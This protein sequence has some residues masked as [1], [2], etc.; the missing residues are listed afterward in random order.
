MLIAF[1]DE[2]YVFWLFYSEG[3]REGLAVQGKTFNPLE[4]TIPLL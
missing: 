2:G 1:I 3:F 4:K